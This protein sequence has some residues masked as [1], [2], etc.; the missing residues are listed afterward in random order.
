MNG[1][2]F[3]ENCTSID[4][5][6]LDNITLWLTG[7]TQQSR[8]WRQ[9]LKA[10]SSTLTQP[11]PEIMTFRE[12]FIQQMQ[13]HLNY[14]HWLDR[15]QSTLLWW[16]IAQTEL[17][18][19]ITPEQLD[20]LLQL[21]TDSPED[22]DTLRQ[23]SLP[24][25]QWLDDHHCISEYRLAF[26]EIPKT[27]QMQLARQHI[28][29][30]GI[31]S[32][33]PQQE[34]IL[35]HAANCYRLAPL[36]QTTP[37]SI[38]SNN[39]VNHAIQW[40]EKTPPNPL[41]AVLVIAN[42][43]NSHNLRERI[44]HW[45]AQ[46]EQH[47]TLQAP[48]RYGNEGSPVQNS[49]RPSIHA[50]VAA[51]QLTLSKQIQPLTWLRILRQLISH[52]D[53][54]R[55][56]L[57]CVSQ[58]LLQQHIT[59]IHKKHLAKLWR[60]IQKAHPKQAPRL[61][62]W[63]KKWLTN[64]LWLNYHTATLTEW[65]TSWWQWAT[66]THYPIC[67]QSH[68]QRWHK[69]IQRCSMHPLCQQ[70][71]L[72]RNQFVQCIQWLN[73]QPQRLLT[74]RDYYI[75]NQWLDVYETPVNGLWLLQTA[76]P[77]ND[78]DWKQLAA[79]CQ[80]PALLI[81]QIS[82]IS[83]ANTTSASQKVIHAFPADQ[84]P[85]RKWPKQ[86][87]AQ[88]FQWQSNCDCQAYLYHTLQLDQKPLTVTNGLPA[89]IFGA[90][91]HDVLAQW[92]QLPI[93]FAEGQLERI[94]NSTIH[95]WRR[96]HIMLHNHA[97]RMITQ[98]RLQQYITKWHSQQI[99]HP[100]AIVSCEQSHIVKLAEHHFRVRVDRID[101]INENEWI[102]IDYKTGAVQWQHWFDQPPQQTQ[103]PLYS[104]LADNIVGIGYAQLH[105]ETPRWL[106]VIAAHID[107]LPEQWK[108]PEL[109]PDASSQD[110][111]SQKT[112]WRKQLEQL[113]QAFKQ[114]TAT[115]KPARRNQSPCEYCQLHH[116]CRIHDRK[117]S[118]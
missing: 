57:D 19:S 29:I 70:I 62:Q 64:H 107:Q 38:E 37:A 51:T 118:E 117:H 71:R 92:G 112:Q 101:A 49:N 8:H 45:H 69:R 44:H 50:I 89:H 17:S 75:T 106:G 94:I 80:Q 66:L 40:L 110:W 81:T 97:L 104:L 3:F 96:H 91:I 56:D 99:N 14:Q 73:Q 46:K 35:N 115:P 93:Q 79:H 105:A 10:I 6:Q 98:Q 109:W 84:T 67:D 31:P 86:L 18:A 24:V 39:P 60:R 113:L 5:N 15:E 12:W 63:R 77:N 114:P 26:H 9:Y 85:V 61:R 11:L 65:V 42:D 82:P 59:Q 23:L 20:Q 103:M 74:H 54:I 30:T 4:I 68:H 36:G 1:K 87:P 34:H 13:I 52:N 47:N 22:H 27:L 55:Y 111:L 53:S 25:Q 108:K 2:S 48:G 28:L 78:I 41:P 76:L 33:K 58:W 32:L 72:N 90:M 88:L 16:H 83:Q 43:D 21:A 95:K 102:I 100:L 7:T 116:V